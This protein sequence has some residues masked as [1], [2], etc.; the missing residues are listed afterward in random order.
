MSN[1]KLLVFALVCALMAATPVGAVQYFFDD[2]NDNDM[3]DWTD[4]EKTVQPYNNTRYGLY[5]YASQGMSGWDRAD[6]TLPN[7]ITKEALATKSFSDTSFGDTIYLSFD[8]M[9]ASGYMGDTYELGMKTTRVYMVDSAT[10]EGYGLGF[11]YRKRDPQTGFFGIITT[12]DYGVTQGG[13]PIG[14]IPNGEITFPPGMFAVNDFSEHTLGLRYDRVN[15]FF[16]MYLDGIWINGGILDSVQNDKCANP[17]TI[18]ASPRNLFNTDPPSDDR[19]WSGWIHTDDIWVGDGF[20]APAEII[21]DPGD[22]DGNLKVDIVDLTALAANWSALPIN[23]GVP[24]DWN[25]GDFDWDWT[26]DIVD[27]TALAANWSFVGSP[28]PVP[29]PATMALL[30]MGGLALLRR[31][32]S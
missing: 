14:G 21:L 18:I 25:Q 1:S 2:F 9:M 29:E 8:I 6:T 17:D 13:A 7:S 31:R 15:G 11:T 26:V 19:D 3:T 27:L 30:A 23:V 22:S 16:D 10:G 24:K 20:N 12:Q 4:T 28:P 32:R 5:G